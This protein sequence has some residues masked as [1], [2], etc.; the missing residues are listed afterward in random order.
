MSVLLSVLAALLYGIADFSGGFASRGSRLANVLVVSQIAG[1]SLALAFILVQGSPLPDL[2][3]LAW[4]LAAGLSGLVGLLLLYRGIA[5]GVVAIVSP[6]SALVSA[7]LPAAFGLL[8]GER[9]SAL[10][11]VGA[12]LCLP[13]LL[14]LSWEA[15]GA[16]DPR[17]TRKSLLQGLA[18]GA[19]FGGFFIFLSLTKGQ[20]GLWPVF[21]ARLASLVLVVVFV[22]A[23][24][25][26]KSL[27]PGDLAPALA[28]GLADMGAN[29]T[30]L[31]ATRLGLLSVV[32]VISSLFPAP[33]VIL[34]R[35]FMKERIPARRIAG[36]G[37][38]L[39]G[40][41]LISLR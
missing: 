25:G 30:F 5:T 41:A 33:T 29:I 22:L 10:A 18:A 26:K 13:A 2:G 11:L 32:S 24:G 6:V 17:R 21:A 3:A 16:V 20:S 1:A 19:G 23:R 31:L 27:A 8:R 35:V 38:A 36:L 12:T 28:A 15:G 9:P 40:V 39:A 34:A 4:S 37:L 7:L 14:L